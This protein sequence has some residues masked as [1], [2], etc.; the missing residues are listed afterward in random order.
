MKKILVP[1]DFSKL[2]INALNYAVQLA[3]RT[4]SEILLLHVFSIPLLTEDPPL[5]ST[6][7]YL[8]E[9]VLASLEKLK[10][11]LEEL[12]P[13]LRISSA[14][15]VG[16]P[17]TGI[18]DFAKDQHVDLIILGAQ[19]IGYIRERILG[20]TASMLI[21]KVETPVMVIDKKVRFKEPKNIVLAVDLAETDD[22][23]VLAPLRK[24]AAKFQSHIC[25]LNIFTEAN[26]IP[27]FGEID[28]SFRLEKAL[29]HTHHTF[30]EV[31]HPNVVMG[32]NDFVKKNDIDL[33]TI[34]SR[35]HSLIERLFNEPLT[36]AMTFHSHVPLLV[37]HE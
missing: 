36:K 14:A 25:I 12:D 32:I 28:E 13:S 1:T 24:L 15:K 4:E 8:E 27:S 23:A 35:K 26:I 11:S 29:K 19:G 37:L 9:G 2:S 33:V 3:K 6:K 22:Q 21:R 31:E 18:M 10:Q 7:Q 20:S 17:V 5:I 30:F 34:I 16:M